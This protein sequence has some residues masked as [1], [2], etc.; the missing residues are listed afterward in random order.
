MNKIFVYGT[1]KKHQPNFAIIKSGVFCGVGR[2]PKSNNFR[3]VSM[4]SFP[5]LI[6]AGNNTPQEINGEIWD[7]DDES[8]KNVD[9]LEGY[10]S[11][12]EREQFTILDSA[13]KKHTCWAYFI[14]DELSTKELTSV[15]NGT[16]YG[17][18]DSVYGVGGM[19]YSA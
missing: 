17:Y 19:D 12:Y 8:F 2:L 15:D 6:Q 3:M 11:F 13:D 4:G 14:P 10:P 1:L 7:V 9:Y 18:E 16:W 5:A